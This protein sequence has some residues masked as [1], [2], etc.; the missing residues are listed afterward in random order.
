MKLCPVQDVC[1]HFT[2]NDNK[3]KNHDVRNKYI[4]TKYLEM[5]ELAVGY[6]RDIMG[7]TIACKISK[8]RKTK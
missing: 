6:E 8:S 7:K 2:T 4:C 3:P 1:V 5:C